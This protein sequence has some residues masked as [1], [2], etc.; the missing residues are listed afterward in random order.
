MKRPGY[1]TIEAGE[2]LSSVLKRAGGTTL[3]AFPPG[4]VLIRESVKLHQQAELERYIA[5][6]RQ[7]LTAQSAGVAAGA[8]GV[9]GAA[10]LSSVGVAEQQ[11][12]GPAAPTNRGDYGTAGIGLGRGSNGLHRATRRHAGRYYSG[13]M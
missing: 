11:V 6:E 9:S 7:R 4:L 2:R 3:D 8:V 12:F 1:F 13:R 10:A 5:S